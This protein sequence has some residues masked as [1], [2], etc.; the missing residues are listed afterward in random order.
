M[1][2]SSSSIER[3]V[4]NSILSFRSAYST[5]N[6]INNDLISL[7]NS[8]FRV[9]FQAG[10]ISGSCLDKS[11]C[12]EMPISYSYIETKRE[13]AL[14]SL[15]LDIN[16]ILSKQNVQV[17]KMKKNSQILHALIKQCEISKKSD[18]VHEVI[19]LTHSLE[20]ITLLTDEVMSC[21]FKDYQFS[22][23]AVK[24]LFLR[25]CPSEKA[26]V[27]LASM[28]YKPLFDSPKVFDFLDI[29]K[30]ELKID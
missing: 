1:A 15:S 18:L 21:V 13:E 11:L 30:L 4:S 2:L 6:E 24:E 8:Y 25:D 20:S 22:I 16:E 19:F 7:G 5:Y 12:L 27:L 14:I 28:L 9:K 29:I 10:K 3:H 26:T 23:A 17:N